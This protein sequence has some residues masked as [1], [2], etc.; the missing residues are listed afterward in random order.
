MNQKEKTFVNNFPKGFQFSRGDYYHQL[1]L[2]LPTWLESHFNRKFPK[3]P[4][5]IFVN[6]M[7]DIFWWEP[8]WMEKVIKKI[9][10][11]PQHSFMFLTKFPEVYVRKFPENCWLGI[12]ATTN[13][14]V[15]KASCYAR[16][17]CFLSI[18]PIMENIKDTDNLPLFD[19][20]I[21]G[22]ETGN[23]KG[24]V[25]PENEWIDSIADYCQKY[26][27]PIFMK[28][29]LKH[30]DCLNGLIQEFPGGLNVRKTN[31]IL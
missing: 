10:E 15:N 27:I 2:F 16:E 31:N 5:R 23:R 20:V 1:K 4:S 21:V 12:T 28:N 26:N 18:E 30:Y 29:N 17:K 24:K 7:S 8:E 19:W 9:N 13:Q 14:G 11:H 6:S 22:A 3:K 25:V